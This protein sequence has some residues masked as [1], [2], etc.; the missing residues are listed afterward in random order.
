MYLFFEAFQGIWHSNKENPSV[1]WN[2][3]LSCPLMPSNY[4]D[5]YLVLIS[6]RSRSGA[7]HSIGLFG[8]VVSCLVLEACISFYRVPDKIGEFLSVPCLH[9]NAVALLFVNA[10]TSLFWE[11]L[12]FTTIGAGA[13]ER[14]T[15]KSRCWQ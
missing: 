11:T 13:S 12:S 2:A 6:S 1:S 9:T 3:A 8:L 7:D 5:W 4:A 14:S 15:G 10:S